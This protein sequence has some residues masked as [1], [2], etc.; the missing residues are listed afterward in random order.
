MDFFV[1]NKC[2]YNKKIKPGQI[3][4]TNQMKIMTAIILNL[5]K[6]YQS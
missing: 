2:Q 4:N 5:C 6:L 1:S 3:K